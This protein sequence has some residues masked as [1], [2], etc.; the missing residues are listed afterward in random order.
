MDE[1]KN[2]KYSFI[3]G[4]IIAGVLIERLIKSGFVSPQNIIASDNKA[5]RLAE[6]KQSFGI[7]TTEENSKC[8]EFGEW[9]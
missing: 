5:E 8:A 1:L 9:V 4:G 2:K 6:L 7:N 3:G